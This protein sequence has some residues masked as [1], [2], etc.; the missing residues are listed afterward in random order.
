[1]SI[2]EMKMAEAR[3]DDAARA[4]A[5]AIEAACPVGKTVKWKRG[6]HVQTGEVVM[7]DNWERVKVRNA[8]SGKEFW[9]YAFHIIA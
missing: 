7:T 3:K 4:Y 5:D 8:K 1:M 9:L 6:E 2:Y